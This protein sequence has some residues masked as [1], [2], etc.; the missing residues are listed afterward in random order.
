[1]LH[2][3]SESAPRVGQSDLSAEAR[4]S[5][6]VQRITFSIR[7]RR[8]GHGVSRA[9]DHLN[10]NGGAVRAERT[11]FCF[12]SPAGSIMVAQPSF[13]NKR[14]SR[15]CRHRQ[16]SAAATVAATLFPQR[17]TGTSGEEDRCRQRKSLNR[18]TSSTL[19]DVADLSVM[20]KFQHRHQMATS[21]ANVAGQQARA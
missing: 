13:L 14:A 18:V 2:S 3:P 17:L 1:M 21:N 11:G 16:L 10:S 20:Q 5:Q 9:T 7:M 12:W 8:V 6:L 19:S 15:S 4:F